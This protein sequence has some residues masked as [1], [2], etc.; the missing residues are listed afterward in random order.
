MFCLHAS[1]DGS[2]CMW[3]EVNDYAGFAPPL[4]MVTL[5]QHS[6]SSISPIAWHH[7]PHS[8]T[9]SPT[10]V[11]DIFD[12]VWIIGFLHRVILLIA[13]GTGRDL[14]HVIHHNAPL[15]TRPMMRKKMIRPPVR[16]S[17]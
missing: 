12:L 6:H 13:E 17:S 1:D 8:K 5:H 10:D 11:A 2:S 9:L 3:S 14:R 15:T 16:R 4:H 7:E